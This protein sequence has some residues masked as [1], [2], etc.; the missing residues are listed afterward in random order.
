MVGCFIAFEG[1]EGSGKTTQIA[2]LQQ[3]LAAQGCNVII[4]R[5]PGG[6]ETAEAIRHLLL[7]GSSEKWDAVAETLLFQAA[8]VEHVK[9]VIAPALSEGKIVLCDRF[10][11]STIVYQGMSKGLGAEFIQTLH[12][13]TLG[14]MLPDM[15]FVLDISPEIGL[16]RAKARNDNE[17]RFENMQLTFHHAVREGFLMLA[18]AEPQRFEVMNAEQSQAQLHQQI[19][20]AVQRHTLIATK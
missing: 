6:C 15:T 13:L 7:T 12:R 5:E 18:K 10:I 16:K 3:A 1:G 20:Q 9:R 19:L 11:D 14:Q 17:N 2:M 4:T 8:R